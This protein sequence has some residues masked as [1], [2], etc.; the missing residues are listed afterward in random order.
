MYF[1]VEIL[2]T[3]TLYNHQGTALV[4]RESGLVCQLRN[5]WALGSTN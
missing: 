2:Y 5:R 4:S 3:E 1:I